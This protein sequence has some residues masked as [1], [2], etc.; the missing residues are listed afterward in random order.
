MKNTE[1]ID[2]TPSWEVLLP[3][4]LHLLQG[5]TS[6]SRKVAIDELTRMAKLADLY[7]AERK[8]NTVRMQYDERGI[9]DRRVADRRVADRRG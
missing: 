6:D 2:M 7:V 9:T 3:V 4:L 1:T 5:E 8:E